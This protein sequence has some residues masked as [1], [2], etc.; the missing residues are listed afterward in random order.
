M[1]PQLLAPPQKRRKLDF[2]SIAAASRTCNAQ[3]PTSALLATRSVCSS[4]HRA[5]LRQV[6]LGLCARCD[7]PTCS[8]CTR[9][10]SM[11]PVHREPLAPLHIPETMPVPPFLPTTPAA[12]L[13]HQMSDFAPL[14]KRRQPE[15]D[16]PEEVTPGE[17]LLQDVPGA[18]CR[19]LVCRNCCF[20][21]EKG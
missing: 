7:R 5:N 16:F 20:E 18:G 4:C 3:R 9:S 19:R 14:G 6:T 1:S 10:C 12:T 17:T 21:S 13:N 2:P 11:R 15:S 8:I